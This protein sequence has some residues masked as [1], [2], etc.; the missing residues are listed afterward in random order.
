MSTPQ[1]LVLRLAG[2]QPPP[3]ARARMEFAQRGGSIGRADDSDWV[4]AAPGISRTHAMVRWLNG[5]F[6][7]E[8]RSTNGML[9]NGAPMT[10]G[11]PAALGDGDRLQ[12]DTFEIEVSL[13]AAEAASPPAAGC[14]EPETDRTTVAAG[15]AP[16]VGSMDPAPSP[17][18]VTD[19]L[20]ADIGLGAGGSLDP[21]DLLGPAPAP[22][23]QDQAPDAGNW[24]HTPASADH[25][26][27][28]RPP[29]GGV[30]LPE[31][32]DLTGFDAPAPPPVASTAP[33][34]VPAPEPV[35]AQ[36]ASQPPPS[37]PPAADAPASAPAR[38]PTAL[39]PETAEIF[40]IVVDG[41]MEVLRARAEIKN[42]F[43][44]PVTIVQRSENNP[45]KFA[46]TPAEAIDRIMGADN[47]AFL[48]GADAFEDAFDDIRCHQMAMLAGMRAAFESLLFH[49]NPDRM[50][51]ELDSSGK[52]SPFSGKGRYWE[53]YRENFANAVKDPDE[54]FRRM[55][56]DEFARAYEA[57]LARL[58]SARKGQRH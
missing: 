21:L 2:S 37:R 14:G 17:Q 6:F 22:P 48:S 56:G 3:G 41:V 45:L 43:R 46:A 53:R 51:Q 57:Q 30:Q 58:K 47:A 31:E 38:Q 49:F 12:M 8:D 40:E 44:L 29:A 25:F 19:D 7:I 55:F 32:W 28:P 18:S 15:P 20:L 33:D 23:T 1:T 5:M 36:P 26:Q 42:T 10:R 35:S 52:R 34:P 39:S 24:N 54:S 11:E 27:P 16:L 50:E 4:L 9:H 13:R